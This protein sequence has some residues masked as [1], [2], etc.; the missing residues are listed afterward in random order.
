MSLHRHYLIFNALI[1]L[2]KSHYLKF[3]P[4]SKPL[5]CLARVLSLRLQNGKANNLWSEGKTDVASI[6]A[7]EIISH[8]VR[9]SMQTSKPV[10]N[11][12]F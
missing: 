12:D 2:L 7:P 4:I 1:L 5:T 8:L 3:S 9:Y 11:T 6:R 10:S